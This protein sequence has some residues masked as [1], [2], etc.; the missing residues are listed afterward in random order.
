[1]KKTLLRR[2]KTSKSSSR[3]RFYGY[4]TKGKSRGRRWRP[5]GTARAHYYLAE[6]GSADLRSPDIAGSCVLTV[7]PHG[8]TVPAIAGDAEVIAPSAPR[9]ACFTGLDQCA[10]LQAVR[11]ITNPTSCLS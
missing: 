11:S 6:S 4:G 1:M 7:H 2:L 8:R 9:I 10:A 3:S 5:L